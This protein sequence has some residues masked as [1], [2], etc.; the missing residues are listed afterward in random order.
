MNEIISKKEAKSKGLKRFFTG[1]P[2]KNSHLSEKYT[3]TGTC[4]QCE[5]NRRILRKDEINASRRK[6]AKNNQDIIK[7]S[8]N[9]WR[10]TNP[11]KYMKEHHK[12]RGYPEPT[13]PYPEDNRCEC[14][15]E[16]EGSIDNRYGKIKRLALDHN[17]ETNEFRGWL[18][19][20]CNTVLGKVKD[21]K[22]IL[23]KLVNYISL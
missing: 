2:C 6:Y 15:N 12:S 19:F 16:V 5:K 10:K 14:C 23:E 17:H 4:V 22:V 18:C 21:S 1:V 7:K 8:R 13:R 9:S 3:S 11:D 20:R